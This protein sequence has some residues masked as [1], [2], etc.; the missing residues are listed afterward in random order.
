MSW[1]RTKRRLKRRWLRRLSSLKGQPVV[2]VG[3][4]A[5]V[6]A[7]GVTVLV[8]VR[9]SASPSTPTTRCV[10]A[11]RIAVLGDSTRIPTAAEPLIEALAVESGAIVRSFALNGHSLWSYG[12]RP[13][14]EEVERFEPDAV[15]L[16][17]GL[18][19]LRMDQ[20]P[21]RVALFTE[22]LGAYVDTL[23]DRLPGVR[24]LVLSVPAAISTHDIGGAAFVVGDP[25]EVTTSLRG[26]YL[27][28]AGSRPY[29]I[30]NDVQA[31]ITGTSP[32]DSATP[33]FLIDQLHPSRETAAR[34]GELI[35]GHMT[36]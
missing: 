21:D 12:E 14:I 29:V 9:P 3:A 15:E 32:D 2:V 5:L 34:I 11:T 17:I 19:D 30:L 4:L 18:N 24:R 36:C 25:A 20:S 35:A 7:V 13:I 6:T 27:A 33:R 23:H 1:R 31:E 26:A 8:N 28:V 10:P 16:S 22:Q